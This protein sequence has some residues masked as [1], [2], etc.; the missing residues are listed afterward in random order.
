MM[1]ETGVDEKQFHRR[2]LKST[3][4]KIDSPPVIIIL[5]LPRS[6]SL[7]IHEYFECNNYRS[8]HYC[9]DADSNRT[10]FPCLEQTCGSCVHSNLLKEIPPFQNCKSNIQVWSQFGVESQ[11][12]YAWFLPQEFALSILHK[13]Y[14]K[15]KWIINARSSS[16]R[17]ATNVLHWNTDTHRLL[18]AYNI[19]Y[20][21]SNQ[22]DVVGYNHYTADMAPDV[23][24]WTADLLYLELKK[25]LARAGDVREYIRRLQALAQVHDRHVKLVVEANEYF[26][27][28]HD[29]VSLNVDDA[30]AGQVLADAFL[31]TRA[32]C[33]RFDGNA[34]DNDWKDFSLKL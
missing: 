4:S 32:D 3:T 19:P 1:N 2:R 25:S 29:L 11:D 14:P 16:K 7:Q 23:Q 24:N 15:A 20:Y 22:T 31:G 9:C 18:T 10:R 13:H 34:L 6:G 27:R 30:N 8:A 12:P 5:G 17:W 26:Q 33:W 21:S 28:S